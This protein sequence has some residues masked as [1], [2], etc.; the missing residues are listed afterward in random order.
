[1]GA[2]GHRLV[3]HLGRVGIGLVNPA[4]MLDV[5][6]EVNINGLLRIQ[7]TVNICDASRAGQLKYDTAAPGDKLIYF[8]NGTDWQEVAVVG[9]GS[10]FIQNCAA[11]QYQIGYD[12]GERYFVY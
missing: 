10:D 12:G 6:G 8:C 9:A 1:M 7:D 2:N 3:L 4:Y 5:N 11:T